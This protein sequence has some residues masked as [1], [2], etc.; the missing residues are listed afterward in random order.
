MTGLNTPLWH[1]TA[2]Q[3]AQAGTATAQVWRRRYRAAALF[4][5]PAI[6][7]GL[8]FA[9]MRPYGATPLIA[10]LASCVLCCLQLRRVRI[11]PTYQLFVILS[12]VIL[13]LS[14]TR[15]LPAAWT[16]LYDGAVAVRHWL[17]VPA[18][19][20]LVTAYTAIFQSYGRT[21]ERRALAL[22][23]LLYTV[24]FAV[25]LA[26][27]DETVLRLYHVSNQVIPIVLCLT[28]FIFRRRRHPL[29]DTALILAFISFTLSSS[30]ILLGLS[31]L[32]LRYWPRPQWVVYGLGIAILAILTLAP[33]FPM[34]MRA[35]DPNAGV[36][37]VM[38]R[39][40]A[41]AVFDTNGVG[42]GYGTE[43]I[44]NRFYGIGLSDWHLSGDL[45]DR[46]FWSTHSTFYDVALRTGVAGLAVFMTWFL[47]LLRI[48]SGL[49]PE[50]KRT[51]GALACAVMIYTAFNP[52]L[53]S[54]MIIF[55]IATLIGTMTWL[56]DK[57]RLEDR[58]PDQ[59]A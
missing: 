30:Q 17:W 54:F 8:G 35:F 12:L 39:D 4:A 56:R 42:V 44:K 58:D 21:L 14:L 19:P 50:H 37:V 1:S 49:S 46:Y 10:V 45:A 59:N 51:Y 55:G 29:V 11:S 25:S 31:F 32:A 27:N 9:V 57:S 16:Q 47:S 18:L 15:S 26:A 5:L 23:A 38:W 34:E 20:L 2:D 3:P 53:V 13:A 28:L 33:F 41:T 6:L 7:Y 43:Y 24:N 40:A 22:A 36:R 48:P 52:A